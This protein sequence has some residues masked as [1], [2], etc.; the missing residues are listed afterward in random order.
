[1]LSHVETS[2]SQHSVLRSVTHRSMSDLLRSRLLFAA[3]TNEDAELQRFTVGEITE[4]KFKENLK[5]LK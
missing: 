2:E 5:I 1:M 3:T 4:Q